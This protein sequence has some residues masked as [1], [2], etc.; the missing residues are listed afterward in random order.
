[1]KN[2]LTECSYKNDIRALEQEGCWKSCSNDRIS[3]QSTMKNNKKDNA[4]LKYPIRGVTASIDSLL[5]LVDTVII[6]CT[7]VNDVFSN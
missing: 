5:Y 2:I 7:S 6:E 1:M 4:C 3:Q